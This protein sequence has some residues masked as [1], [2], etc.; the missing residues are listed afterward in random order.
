MH[1]RTGLQPAVGELPVGGSH[2]Q[3][4]NNVYMDV[5]EASCWHRLCRRRST[6]RWHARLT[7]RYGVQYMVLLFR[8]HLARVQVY[9]LSLA[10]ATAR[11]FARV[12][13]ISGCSGL[14]LCC[15]KPMFPLAL[16]RRDTEVRH[17]CGSV[18]RMVKALPPRGL[19]VVLYGSKAVYKEN[20]TKNQLEMSI[21]KDI[22]KV[23][24]ERIDAVKFWLIV[25]VIAA[26]VLM[27]KEFAVSTTCNVLWNWICLFVMPLFIFIS[28]YFSHKKDR[29][30]FLSSLWKLLE[31]LIIFQVVA[32]LFYVDTL[33]IRTILT[34]WF[35]L[36]YL[37]SLIYWRLMLQIIPEKILRQKKLILISTFCIAI[38]AGFFPFDKLL[39]IQRTLALMPFFFLGYYMKGKNIYLPDKYRL[40]CVL[41]LIGI[42]AIL[43]FYPHRIKYLLYYAPY[44]NIYGAAIRMIAF[45]IAIPMSLAFLKV[46]YNT[47]W[48]ARQGR[49][50]MQ[51]YI[52][53][54]L[55]MPGN[56]ALI[57]P[58][59]IVVVSKLNIPM[60]FITAITI[61]IVTTIGL[62]FILKIPFFRMLTNPSSFFL[63]GR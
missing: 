28:G 19:S 52:Y 40:L 13:G 25:L 15:W 58:P 60:T 36:W 59:L 33:S 27:R 49:L 54:G 57:I 17:L 7:N 10:A 2:W 14:D 44:K 12:A 51:Y 24:D 32:L 42:L 31:P 21:L 6:A 3:E 18:C 63:R 29:E 20:K 8:Q 4:P 37:L 41:F 62:S 55:I 47:P 1:R 48:I 9:R 39:S 16:C 26:H 35:M 11:P 30:A 38:L 43:F 22:T 61:I 5:R 45:G 46:C 50:S 34:P 56:S 23:R 53:Q